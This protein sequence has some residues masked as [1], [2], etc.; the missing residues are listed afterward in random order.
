MTVSSSLTEKNLAITN[1]KTSK[2]NRLC[3]ALLCHIAVESL[4][5][6]KRPV[7]PNYWE[8]REKCVWFQITLTTLPCPAHNTAIWLGIFEYGND[9]MAKHRD[10]ISFVS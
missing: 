4:V 10:K 1:K 6:F 7:K 5:G 9:G 2:G 8:M 3:Y